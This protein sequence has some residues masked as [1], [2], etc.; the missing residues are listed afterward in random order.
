MPT[1]SSKIRVAI[2]TG[3]DNEERSIAL[4]SSLYIKDCLHGRYN[5]SIYDFPRDRDL[6]IQEHRSIDVA[7]PVFHGKGGED[8]TV[9]GFLQTLKI[10]YVFSN[11]EAHAVGMN[12]EL[13]KIIA[14]YNAIKTARW[15]R[16]LTS[17]YPAKPPFL[18]A[19]IKP[20]DNGSSIGVSIV[21][22]IEQYISAMK[23]ASKFTSEILIE[24]YIKGREYTIAVTDGRNRKTQALP[25]IYIVPTS[26][27]FDYNNKYNGTTK[28]ICPAPIDNSLAEKLKLVATTMHRA[29]G[30]RHI[31]RTDCIVD[32][33]GALYFLEINTIPGLTA[34]SL[35][36][37]TIATANIKFASLLDQWISEAIE[38]SV[39]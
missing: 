27:F 34:Q 2:L 33:K 8:G 5:Y 15:I 19:V 7:I 1:T 16:C 36:P 24:Q 26:G 29:I 35:T 22:T 13:C 17:E 23:F 38:G 21:H 4:K 10:P 31:S 6:F 14:I 37:K 20:I 18:P 11:T 30:A 12:K 3:G 32:E 39:A 9:Q 25:V 28:E